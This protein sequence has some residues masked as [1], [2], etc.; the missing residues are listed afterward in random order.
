MKKLFLLVLIFAIVFVSGCKGKKEENSVVEVKGKYYTLADIAKDFGTSEQQLSSYPKDQL[1]QIV[2]WWVDNELIYREALKEKL[3]NDPAVKR[4]IKNI[5]VNNYVS[6]V[7]QSKAGVTEQDIRKYYE[8]HKK[9]YNTELRIAHITLKNLQEAGS[10]MGMLKSGKS[11]SSLARKFSLDSTTARS[12]GIIAGWIRRGDYAALPQFEDAAYSLKKIGEISGIVQTPMGY[13]I[14]KLIGRR[15][16]TSPST[17][18]QLKKSI[19]NRLMQERQKAVI[20]SLV[21]SLKDQYKVKI[22]V[23]GEGK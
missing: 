6:K 15:K 4:A 22:F 12:G 9:D 14:L 7:F 17:Y 8:G 18:E 20:D 23:E 3:N 5:M 1:K 10:V 16:A 13:E 2:E 21:K 11:F 19:Y